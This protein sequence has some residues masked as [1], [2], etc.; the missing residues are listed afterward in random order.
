M[1]KVGIPVCVGH[2]WLGGVNYF[3]SLAYALGLADNHDVHVTY[4]TDDPASFVEFES[5]RFFVKK[6]PN[7]FPRGVVQRGVNKL[8]STNFG[9]SFEASRLGVDL[10]TH[11][12]VGRFSG[13]SDLF[14]M[15]D[16]Q[17][18]CLPD[19][20]SK[21]DI[22]ARD[23]AV[24]RVANSGRILLSSYSAQND[25]RA[26]FPE[27][28]DVK[29]YVLQFAPI[30]DA[31][32]YHQLVAVDHQLPSRFFFL[33]N[34]FWRHKNHLV[35]LDALAMLPSS[36]CVVCTGRLSDYR[37]SQHIYEIRRRIARNSLENRFLMLGVVDRQIFQSLLQRSIAVINPSLFEGWSTTVEEAKYSGKRLVLSD[38]PVHREQNPIDALYFLPDNPRQLAELLVQVI[39]EF[40]ISKEEVRQDNARLAYPHAARKFGEDYLDIVKSCVGEL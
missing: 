40:D 19:F 35:V 2:G 32:S 22:V 1:I 12:T 33:P 13:V 37:G 29:S 9:L 16:F 6:A 18:K 23:A 31:C 26:F 5:E 30:L 39:D 20:F 3:R 7:C 15:P 27:M 11:A 17:H 36:Y 38:I 8:F 34:Q 25:F 28:L 10:V 21:R 14:W 24:A 4:L